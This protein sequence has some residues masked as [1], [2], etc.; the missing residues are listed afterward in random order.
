MNPL[1]NLGD[2]NIVR[3]DLFNCGGDAAKLY[4]GIADTAIAEKT[5]ALLTKGGIIGGVTV[6]VIGFGT[7][8]IIKGVKFWKERKKILA[9]KPELEEQLARQMVNASEQPEGGSGEADDE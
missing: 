7:Q 8:A 4:K 9:E 5:P 1:E 6:L 3:N 2:Y